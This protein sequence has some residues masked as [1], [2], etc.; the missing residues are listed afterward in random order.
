MGNSHEIFDTIA[1][2]VAQK[3]SG[4]NAYTLTFEC[5]EIAGAAR[6]VQFVNIA[7]T[8]LSSE[9]KPGP[10]LDML[11]RRPLGFSQVRPEEGQFDVIYQIVGHG[12]QAMAQF[13][14]GDRVRI[15]GPLGMPLTAEM[16]KAQ[17]VILVGGGLG[18]PPLY[19]LA[20]ELI[21]AGKET[22]VIAGARAENLLIMDTQKCKLKRPLAGTN[23]T[24][25]LKPFVEIGAD[26][27]VTLDTPTEGF[28][29]GLV[30]E[31]LKQYLKQD[32]D[33][34][35]EIVTCGP[36]VMMKFIAQ[37][38]QE[39]SVKCR[40]IMEAR[41]GC[42]LGACQACV[43]KTTDGYKRVCTEGPV[44]DAEDIVWT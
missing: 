28:H 27:I 13:K 40:L 19:D 15:L 17:T 31:P 10:S 3:T 9:D 22:I 33:G 4:T 29:S 11:L 44:F 5:P 1:T 30:T 38:A 18:L 34:G 8:P 21:K 16:I 41:M 12:T 6:P 23:E 24:T 42:G 7:T 25:G 43:C 26:C 32:F 39:K 2:V 37:I 36:P 14:I 35:V 20:P